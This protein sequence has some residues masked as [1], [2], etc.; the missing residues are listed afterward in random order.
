MQRLAVQDTAESR[1]AL[2]DQLARE[3][4]VAMEAVHESGGTDIKYG[5]GYGE[6]WTQ[7]ADVVQQFADR[8]GY[9]DAVPILLKAGCYSPG[10]P[11]VTWLAQHGR[12]LM[13]DAVQLFQDGNPGNRANALGVL[14]EMVHLQRTGRPLGLSTE[15]MQQIEHLSIAAAKDPDPSVKFES[16]QVLK[17]LASPES[18]AALSKMAKSDPTFDSQS[19]RF[20]LRDEAAKAMAESAPSKK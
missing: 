10:S 18:A 15:D 2:I 8:P 9:Q 20:P 17:G 13:P 1:R 14:A 4:Q 6:Y 5:E 3:N 12:S 16:I 7:L 11:F 19:G